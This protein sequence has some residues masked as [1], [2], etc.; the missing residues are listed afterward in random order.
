MRC[1]YISDV[2]T[3]IKVHT[4]LHLSIIIMSELDISNSSSMWWPRGLTMGKPGNSDKVHFYTTRILTWPFQVMLTLGNSD[5]E[6]CNKSGCVP[7]EDFDIELCMTLSGDSDT[8]LWQNHQ[9]LSTP[10]PPHHIDWYISHHQ[11]N[12]QASAYLHTTIGL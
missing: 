3:A 11:Y 8:C 7:R 1:I 6:F 9:G 4:I 12:I 2:Y 10:P 5:I